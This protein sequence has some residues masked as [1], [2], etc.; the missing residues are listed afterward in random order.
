MSDVLAAG[1][2][3]LAAAGVTTPRVD[4]ELLLAAAA[5]VPRGR[6]L[7]QRS[8]PGDVLERYVAWVARRG[9]REPVQHITGTAPF[10]RIELAVGPGVFVPRPETELLV[11]AVLP[12]L[13]ALRAPLVFDLCA[14][15]GALALA[16]ADEV[17]DATVVAVEASPA[18]FA[19]LI[20]NVA[21]RA[22]VVMVLGDVRDPGVLREYTGRADAVVAN[23]PYVPDDVAVAAEVHADPPEAVFA[24]QDGMA[25]L[26]AVAQRAA[27]LLRPGGWFAVEHD[28]THGAAVEELL[29]QDGRWSDVADHADLAGRPRFAT[30]RR[31]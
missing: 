7:S 4:A 13:R 25:I 9:N 29:A 20:R 27:E 2:R 6:L 19:W 1:T 24:G 23:P 28:E 26:P 17:P 16:I 14:G 5:G 8:L 3:Q 30:A 12:H 22:S 21:G 11:D 15:T 31:A 18:A 10:R